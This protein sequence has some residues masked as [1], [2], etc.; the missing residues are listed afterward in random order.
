MNSPESN[1]AAHE[2][3]SVII[4][5]S[6]KLIAWEYNNGAIR[7]RN[8][9]L[10]CFGSVFLPLGYYLMGEGLLTKMSKEQLEE[11][12]ALHESLKNEFTELTR[13]Y[14]DRVHD[15]PEEM[16]PQLLK[17]LDDLNHIHS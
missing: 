17:K 12:R 10:E 16:R 11:K 6:E 14:P 7:P 9:W 8:S 2:E 3:Y 15:V 1:H 5:N 13:K 4:E